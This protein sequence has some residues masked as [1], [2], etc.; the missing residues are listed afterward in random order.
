MK[1]TGHK[2][3]KEGTYTKGVTDSGRSGAHKNEV[4]QEAGGR[5]MTSRKMRRG[6]LV[7]VKN[8][9]PGG[10]ARAKVLRAL[11]NSRVRIQ[12]CYGDRAIEVWEEK[13][14]VLVSRES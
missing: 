9:Y 5:Q 13:D 4:E 11:P 1:R 3:R 14:L 7:A 6:S 12:F 8:A 2:N 10:G